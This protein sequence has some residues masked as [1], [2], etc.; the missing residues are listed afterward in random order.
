MVKLPITEPVKLEKFL[1]TS[2][3]LA[4]KVMIMTFALL[5]IRNQAGKAIMIERLK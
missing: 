2:R 3:I 5:K 1:T 4:I